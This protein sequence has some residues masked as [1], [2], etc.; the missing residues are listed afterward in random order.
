MIRLEIAK[1]RWSGTVPGRDELAKEIAVS[2]KTVE[3][4]LQVLQKEGLLES[5]GPGRR[6]RIVS[7]KDVPTP[8]LKVAI[9]TFE[10]LAMTEGYLVEMQHRFNEAGH[11]AFFT[12][13]SLVE[14]GFDVKK[15][16]RFVQET[17]A[18]AWVVVADPRDVLEWFV[19]Q[20]VPVFA[21]SGGGVA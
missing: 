18:D 10:P 11:S 8:S 4:A 20:P 21:C 19:A 1:G 3:A 7:G 9:L 14:L 15:V 17:K 13:K 16:S 12:S 6:R 2:G 5:Q